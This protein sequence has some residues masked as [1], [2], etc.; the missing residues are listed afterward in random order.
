MGRMILGAASSLDGYWADTLGES[1]F[2]PEASDRNALIDR[3]VE[4][5]GAVV[6]NAPTYERVARCDW[7]ADSYGLRTPLFVVTDGPRRDTGRDERLNLRFVPDFATAFA[8]ARKIAG[9][10]AVLVVGG[11]GALEAA[12]A[13]DEADEIL[14][15]IVD[16]N[17]GHGTRLFDEPRQIEG[18]YVSEINNAPGA[19]HMRLERRQR[20]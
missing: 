2:P 20:A 4:G 19:V 6:M 15:R 11:N 3:L 8:E 13:R 17:L 18:Y 5:C 12:M 10:R 16:R 14:L 1:V 9:E 7:Y